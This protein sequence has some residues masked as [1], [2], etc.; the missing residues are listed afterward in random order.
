MHNIDSIFMHYERKREN[1]Y[2]TI[3]IYEFLM[4]CSRCYD[5]PY[6]L[7]HHSP[8][9]W[10]N[11]WYAKDINKIIVKKKYFIAKRENCRYHSHITHICVCLV[12]SSDKRISKILTF[13]FYSI[14]S[15]IIKIKKIES[16]N[17][18]I[19][20]GINTCFVKI[21]SFISCVYIDFDVR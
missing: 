20:L 10:N 2:H 9:L 21:P 5:L 19:T 12:V 6:S 4:I 16:C 13:I 8:P 11:N 7:F 3:S 15:Y 1:C 14:I 17:N 18:R